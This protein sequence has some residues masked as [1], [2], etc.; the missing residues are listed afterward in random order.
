MWLLLSNAPSNFANLPANAPGEGGSTLELY[1]GFLAF[2]AVVVMLIWLYFRTQQ[3]QPSRQPP[4][5]DN[6]NPPSA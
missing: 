1:F 6:G 4:E 5:R 2:G 3:P